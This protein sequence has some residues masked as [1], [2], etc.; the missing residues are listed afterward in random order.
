[1]VCGKIVI[2]RVDPEDVERR[3]SGVLIQNA[4]ADESGTPYLNAQ[5]R[6]ILISGTCGD[7]YALLC[8]SN[9]PHYH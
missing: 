9:Y 5:S 3:R 1:M 7:C 4:F 8:S 6:E 2:L